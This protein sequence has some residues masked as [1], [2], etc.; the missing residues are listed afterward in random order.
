LCEGRDEASTLSIITIIMH[1]KKYIPVAIL[2]LA[3]IFTTGY[4]ALA[5]VGGQSEDGGFYRSYNLIDN[6]TA[7]ATSSAVKIV[8]AKSVTFLFDM[9]GPNGSGNGTTTYA[10]EVSIDNLTTFYDY[11]K[12]VTNNTSLTIASGATLTGTTTALYTMDLSGDSYYGMRCL[13]VENGTTTASCTALV[14]Y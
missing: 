4:V 6:S 2:V 3:G 8:G 5:I 14:Q 10:V 1:I 9:G 7:S 11:N 13:S 12:L